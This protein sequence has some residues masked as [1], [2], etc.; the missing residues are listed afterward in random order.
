[1]FLLSFFIW[2][3][4]VSVAVHQP[5][6]ACGEQGLLSAAVHRLLIAVICCGTQALGASVLVAVVRGLSSCGSQAL[7]H[8]DFDSCGTGLELLLIMFIMCSS[9]LL[10]L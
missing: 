5:S 9:N 3:H 8:V 1:M 10:N 6:L 7:E 4:W 2:P